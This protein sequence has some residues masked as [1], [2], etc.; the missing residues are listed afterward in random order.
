MNQIR[1]RLNSCHA[2][3][4]VKEK[5]HPNTLIGMAF[6]C[7]RLQNGGVGGNRT[8]V[9]KSST[10]SSTYLVI[11]FDLINKARIDTFITDD[12]LGFRT[13]LRDAK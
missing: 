8:R 12:S 7:F 2:L 13:I 3:I 5:R 4:P 11:S 9:R 6:V 1:A 10:T